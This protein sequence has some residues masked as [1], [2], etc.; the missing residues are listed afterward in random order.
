[1]V[2]YRGSYGGICGRMREGERRKVRE[3]GVKR[4]EETEKLTGNGMVL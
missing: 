3:G 4:E 2:E 1:M